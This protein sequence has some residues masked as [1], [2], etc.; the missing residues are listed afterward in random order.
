[1]DPQYALWA[2]D[3]VIANTTRADSTGGFAGF[4]DIMANTRDRE[5]GLIHLDMEPYTFHA[6]FPRI[7]L[8]DALFLGVHDEH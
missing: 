8:G 5:L 4:Q 3:G 2:Q 7:E 6:S 1:M